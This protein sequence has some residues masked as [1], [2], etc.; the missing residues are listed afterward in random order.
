M[1]IDEI[2]KLSGHD[3]HARTYEKVMELPSYFKNG[4]WWTREESHLGHLPVPDYDTQPDSWWK[5]VEMMMNRD[6]RF[7]FSTVNKSGFEAEFWRKTGEPCRSLESGDASGKT[8][9]EAICRAALL[10]LLDTGCEI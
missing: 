4:H 2:L 10:A 9:G 7:S 8:P 6:W 5:L 3:L 1:P